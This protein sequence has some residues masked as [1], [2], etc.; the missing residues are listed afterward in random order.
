MSCRW[1]SSSSSERGRLLAAFGLAFAAAVASCTA[2]DVFHGAESAAPSSSSAVT[3]GPPAA[4]AR[5][6]FNHKFHLERGPTCEDCHAGVEKSDKAPMPTLE[7]CMECH[8][9][10]DAKK[11][12]E[13]TVGAFLDK[14]GGA[15]IWSR[16]TAQS[17]DIVFSHRTHVAKKVA[18][19][20]CHKGIAESTAV[21]KDLAVD[22]DAC[23]TCHEQKGAKNDCATCHRAAQANV[24]E[25]RGP[26][27]KPANHDDAWRRHHG[28]ASR[29]ASTARADKCDTCHGMPDFPQESN[30]SDCHARTKP[31][32]HAVQWTT[33]HGQ[34]VRR[35]PGLVTSRCGACHDLPAF[36]NEA[37]CTGC[38]ATEPPRDHS[39]FWRNGAGHGLAAA[40]DRTRCDACHKPDACASCHQQ[41]AP[42]SHRGGWGAP[43][44]GHCVGCHLPLTSSEPGGC[45]TCHRGTPSHDAAPRK[46]S[47][48]RPDFQCAQCHQH[49]RHADNGTN[50]NTCHR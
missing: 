3:T 16:V 43:R 10:I 31:A 32:N 11:P 42:R 22:M 6:A 21:T 34:A 19:A 8:E 12:K 30:C 14:P 17:P 26:F 25:G 1:R 4:P 49:M 20:E 33:M 5:I 46:P 35:D 36:P 47:W 28:P 9:E 50:C 18:C 23:T 24:A 48:H 27:F 45:A 13:K 41:L 29:A 38:H 15:P 2:F 40:M 44:D 7:T 39:Q 37:R